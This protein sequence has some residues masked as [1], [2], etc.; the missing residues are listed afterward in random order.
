LSDPALA[1]ARAALQRLLDAHEPWPALAVD[2]H[3]H[4]VASNR[5]VP[6]LMAGVAPELLQPPM[7]VLRLTLH[8]QGLGPMVRNLRAWRDHVLMRLERQHAATGDAALLRLRDE[9]ALLPMPASATHGELLA[10][11][12]DMAV[13]LTLDS[14]LG[15]LNF[16]TTITVF[17]APHDV[18]LAELAVETLLPADAPTAAA[19]R[20]LHASLPA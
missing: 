17:G 15:T 7:N 1:T 10:G 13:P 20:A 16:I 8:P 3:W 19:L 14:P 9:L 2:R 6:L 4:L 12:P 11:P 5:M 18:T